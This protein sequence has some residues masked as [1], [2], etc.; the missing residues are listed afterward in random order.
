[1]TRPLILVTNDD[2]VLSPGLEILAEAVS[3]LGELL[4]C[5]PET[6]RSGTGHAITLHSHLRCTPVREG[7]WSV[8]GTPVDC[9]YLAANHLCPRRPALVVSGI[10]PGFNLGTDVFYS[11]TVGAAAEGYLR[12]SSAMAIS[13]HAREPQRAAI[14]TI[15]ALARMLLEL[16]ERAL[17]NVNV[18]ELATVRGDRRGATPGHGLAERRLAGD[19]LDPETAALA[20]ELP[21]LVTRLG[22]RPYEDTVEKRHDPRGNPYYWIGGPPVQ[23]ELFE[24]EDTWAIAHGYVS[25]TPL[26]LDITAPELGP[27][28]ERIA[29]ITLEPAPASA[30]RRGFA[31]D[32]PDM[33]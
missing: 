7:W 15:R 26:V 25:V 12:G 5:A 22:H 17:L 3:P 21:L 23:A 18:P 33:S 32:P 19:A 6:E 8:S 28:R 27:W 13:C 20:A 10:N 2:G 1:M 29:E 30:E 9:V 14:P 11:G 24:G 16:Q 31:V 4:V